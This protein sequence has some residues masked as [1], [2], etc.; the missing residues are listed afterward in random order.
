MELIDEVRTYVEHLMN[1]NW[2]LHVQFKGNDTVEVLAHYRLHRERDD[3]HPFVFG[4]FR[5]IEDKDRTL[6]HVMLETK[7]YTVINPKYVFEY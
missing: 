7:M 5:T 4:S 2:Y 3:N 1:W 6:T